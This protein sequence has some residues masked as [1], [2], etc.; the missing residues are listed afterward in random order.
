[1][2]KLTLALL[3]ATAIAGVVAPA[4]ATLAQPG[5]SVPW[6]SINDRQADLDRRIDQGVRNGSL[7]QA[8]AQRLRAEFRSLVQLEAQYRRSGNG[9]NAQEKADLN[10]RYDIL[11]AKVRFER[12]DRDEERLSAALTRLSELGVDALP[13]GS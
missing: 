3:A 8:E 6:A 2:K 7:T 1:M 9:M 12:N 10:R 5:P 11:N 4:T 13:P